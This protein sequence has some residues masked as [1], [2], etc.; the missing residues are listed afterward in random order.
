MQSSD[1]EILMGRPS[2][3]K[4]LCFPG[5]LLLSQN[6]LLLIRGFSSYGHGHTH[7]WAHFHRR[8]AAAVKDAVAKKPGTKSSLIK[9]TQ[10]G[11]KLRQIDKG[12]AEK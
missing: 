1:Q 11:K 5:E 9:P 10:L 6:K 12:V 3:L 7:P 4:V 8:S 2:V